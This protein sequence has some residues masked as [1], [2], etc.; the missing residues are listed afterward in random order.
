MLGGYGRTVCPVRIC[1]DPNNAIP[2]PLL[3]LEGRNRCCIPKQ[4]QVPS[5]QSGKFSLV[6]KG[7]ETLT[8]ANAMCA[9][10]SLPAIARAP[11]PIPQSLRTPG[12]WGEA[13]PDPGR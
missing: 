5:V 13:C 1:Y 6:T 12:W 7:S 3:D 11:S 4:T 10:S 2:V 8:E 9:P